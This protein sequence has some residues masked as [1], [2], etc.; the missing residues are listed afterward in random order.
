[1]SIKKLERE[2]INLLTTLN[3]FGMITAPPS[4]V[5]SIYMNKNLANDYLNNDIFLN[6]RF[7]VLSPNG[8]EVYILKESGNPK[9]KDIF[10]LEHPTGFSFNIYTQ[11]NGLPRHLT[12]YKAVEEIL[13]RIKPLYRQHATLYSN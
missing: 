1:M 2:L 13:Y 3:K 9:N 4:K 5:L 10:H 11:E 6:L 8:E 12:M 7:K